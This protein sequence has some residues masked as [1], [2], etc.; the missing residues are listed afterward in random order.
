MLAARPCL[1]FYDRKLFGGRGEKK[2]NN[3]KISHIFVIAQTTQGQML[4]IEETDLILF[5]C[6]P[7]VMNLDDLTK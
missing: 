5:Q 7:S 6:Y 1:P 3:N 4:F 2:K